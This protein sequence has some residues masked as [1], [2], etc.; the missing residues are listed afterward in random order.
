M[1]TEERIYKALQQVMDP[2]IPVLSVL[3]LGMITK[4]AVSPDEQVLIEMIPTFA[5]CP[6]IHFIKDSI[7]NTLEK[8]L[9]R[10]VNVAVNKTETWNSNRL[11]AEARRN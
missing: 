8:E 2:E 1:I 6:A 3:E 5:A 9:G 10:P 7:K 11:S 4:V